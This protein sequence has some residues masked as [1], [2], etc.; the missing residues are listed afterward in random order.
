M[1]RHELK[2]LIPVS[3]EARMLLLTTVTPEQYAKETS[4][5]KVPAVV[6][7]PPRANGMVNGNSSDKD[8]NPADETASLTLKPTVVKRKSNGESPSP[9]KR[10][11]LDSSKSKAKKKMLGAMDV[12]LKKAMVPKLVDYIKDED[13]DVVPRESGKAAN[14]IVVNDNLPVKS[15]PSSSRKNSSP[16]K[17][18]QAT[19]LEMTKKGG[20][21]LLTSRTP[22]KSRLS[23]QNGGKLIPR[24]LPQPII[25]RQLMS[26]KK[27]KVFRS[28]KY[29]LTLTT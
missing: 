13:A 29:K 8:S 11:K 19:L 15:K 14:C 21:K 3:E 22:S 28:H 6:P 2:R 10:L 26:L 1:L 27:E 24:K 12:F 18:K 7:E 23:I 16:R 9:K 20:V 17:K 4:K 5:P 25:V